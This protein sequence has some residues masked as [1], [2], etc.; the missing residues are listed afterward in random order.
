MKK[1]SLLELVA[2]LGHSPESAKALVLSGRVFVNGNRETRVGLKIKP[3]S[4]LEVQGEK[5]YV[6]RAAHK[7]LG[8]LEIFK[9]EV[10]GRIC[11]DLGA[12]HG[13]FTQVMLEAG[14]RRVYA[15]DVAYGI[16]DYNLRQDPRV[17]VL[18]RRNARD[19]EAEWLDSEDLS[20]PE[21]FLCTA[22]LSF[23]SLRSILGPLYR[24]SKHITGLQALLLIGLWACTGTKS[25]QQLGK[26]VHRKT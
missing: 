1:V 2:A 24:L 18:E 6:S 16:F 19:L 5:K 15:V 13:G 9:P 21:G 23:I 25:H 26:S 7:L 10:Q 20:N 8:A 17:V 4:R 22:D 14:A 3:D 11:L 12:S